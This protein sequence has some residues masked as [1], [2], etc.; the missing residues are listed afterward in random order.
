MNISLIYTM[1]LSL[2]TSKLQPF[3]IFK[4]ERNIFLNKLWRLEG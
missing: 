4:S 3:E 2:T 1:D